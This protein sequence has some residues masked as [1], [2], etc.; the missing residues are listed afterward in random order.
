MWCWSWCRTQQTLLKLGQW[1]K[2]FY[3]WNII[4]PSF[5][6]LA[7][8][9]FGVGVFC[10]L[11]VGG[12][13]WWCCWPSLKCCVWFK[14]FCVKYFVIE[15]IQKYLSKKYFTTMT[16]LTF[17]DLTHIEAFFLMLYFLF[18]EYLLLNEWT[19]RTD[20]WLRGWWGWWWW[21]SWPPWCWICRSDLI[22]S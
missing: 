20:G 9:W 15:N 11:C 5:S 17:S 18:S 14:Y 10:L 21:C 19:E 1:I 2:Y 7:G 4:S 13:G 22:Q 8:D 3:Q 12:G 6:C 16:W